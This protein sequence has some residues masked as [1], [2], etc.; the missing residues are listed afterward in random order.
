MHI[1]ELYL[2]SWY[3][4]HKWFTESVWVFVFFYI[5]A[6]WTDSKH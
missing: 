2:T 6:L 1:K 5:C 4:W 3:R